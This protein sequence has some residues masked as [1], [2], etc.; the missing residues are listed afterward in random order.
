MGKEKA[1]NMGGALNIVIQKDR[2]L[3]VNGDLIFPFV[4]DFRLSN[5]MLSIKIS[6]MSQ[7]S[8]TFCPHDMSGKQN[9]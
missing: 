1:A 6:I 7:D 2:S 4:D 9:V 8:V 3:Y 5:G